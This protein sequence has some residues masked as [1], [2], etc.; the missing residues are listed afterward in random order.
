M[1]TTMTTTAAENVSLVAPAEITAN[2]KNLYTPPGAWHGKIY[3]MAWPYFFPRHAKNTAVFDKQ[4][5][6]NKI[7]Q[8]KQKYFRFYFVITK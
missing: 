5:C 7:L 6:S 8:N 2:I 1:M 4:A 3:G